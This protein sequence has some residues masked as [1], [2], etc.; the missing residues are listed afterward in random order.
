[1]KAQSAPLITRIRLQCDGKMVNRLIIVI[2]FSIILIAFYLLKRE[3]ARRRRI[4]ELLQKTEQETKTIISN[5][6]AI[7]FKGYPDWTVNFIDNRIEAMLGYQK[8]DFDSRHLKWSDL[9]VEEDIPSVKITF[10]QALKGKKSYVRKYRV[11]NKKGGITWIQERGQIIYK[12]D[13]Q[14]DFISGI[15]FD[16]TE[17]RETKK[18]IGQLRQ[19]ID[20]ILDSA[21]EG[22]FGLD[23]NGNHTFV[24]PSAARILGYEVAEL[25]GK[26]SHSTWH[27]LKPDGSPYPEEECPIYDTFRKGASHHVRNEV[28]WRKDGTSFPVAYSGSPIIEEGELVGAVVTFWDISERKRAEA[29]REKL[30]KELQ[31]ALAQVKTLKGFLPICAHCKKIRDDEGYWRQI[32]EYIRDHSEAEFSHGICPECLKRVYPEYYHDDKEQ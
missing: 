28:F 30:I 20:M 32:E 7:V 1:M 2:S 3:T 16:I 4:E 14:I 17:Y 10:I 9:I 8:D 31:D 22:I 6:P 5:I 29:E 24:N 25:I 26:H 15:F 21:W 18:A 19:R 13:G 27:Y 23:V 11:K 12:K